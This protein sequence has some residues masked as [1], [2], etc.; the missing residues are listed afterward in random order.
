MAK[1]VA[2]VLVVLVAAPSA[3]AATITLDN[4]G[5]TVVDGT[6]L[7][8]VGLSNGP[9]LDG[10]SP[11][12]QNGWDELS[13]AGVRMYRHM[14]LLPRPAEPWTDE[15]LAQALVAA[16]AAADR[17]SFLFVALREL[18]EAQPGSPE[19]AMLQKVVTQLAAH[20]GMGIWKG[21]DEPWW[22]DVPVEKIAH[23]YSVVKALDSNH[24][25]HIV[26]A[27]RGIAE[28]LA[29]YSAVTDIH[30]ADPYPI[31]L[32]KPVPDLH[33]AGR[34]TRTML[35][36]TPSKGVLMTQP[37][38]SSGQNDGPAG[39]YILPRYTQAR[40][41][42]YDA[43]INGARGLTFYGG[44]LFNCM[45]TRDRALG[46]NW[47]YWDN[48]LGRI[49]RE[50]APHMPLHAA[51]V[52]PGTGVGLRTNSRFSQVVSRQVNG[53][54]WVFVANR[55]GKRNIRIS[56][57]PAGAGP[58]KVYMKTRYIRLVNR[59]FTDSFQPWAVRVYRFPLATD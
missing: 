53:I 30:G 41:M 31:G 23:S 39:P 57:F 51:L 6:P 54:L 4:R 20:P 26:Q 38:C 43:I 17:G 50:I 3:S 28:D 16:Q 12:G 44:N 32:R 45:N 2:L 55:Q 10:V 15:R 9:P 22:S 25:H 34:W 5:V 52:S 1:L 13:S 56:N 7:F 49:V 48:V 46:W 36:I 58:G 14:P 35:S 11:R 33:A 42:V 18:T 40:Y 47:T 59:G 24:P 37:I 29:P 27:A 8:I 21:A 19:A